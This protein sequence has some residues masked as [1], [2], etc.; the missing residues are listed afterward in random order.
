MEALDTGWRKGCYSGTTWER[1]FGTHVMVW[2]FARR[3]NGRWQVATGINGKAQ[4]WADYCD[5]DGSPMQEYKAKRRAT[6][7]A[8]KLIK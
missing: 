1:T 6:A 5:D 8:K 4:M 2:A 7:L 3:V